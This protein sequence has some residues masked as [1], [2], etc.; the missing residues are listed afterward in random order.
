MS[1]TV[2]PLLDPEVLCLEGVKY[3]CGHFGQAQS[4]LTALRR[5]LLN[6]LLFW[7]FAQRLSLAEWDHFEIE[8]L[9]PGLEV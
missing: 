8:A 5:Q 6:R 4:L 3:K 9:V 7:L 2:R 1:G